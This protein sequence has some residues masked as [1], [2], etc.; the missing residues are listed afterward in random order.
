MT[1]AQRIMLRRADEQDVVAATQLHERLTMKGLVRAGYYRH[2]HG[3][4]FKLTEKGKRAR[5][6]L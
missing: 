6:Q 5:G 4:V 1:E 3:M 2:V